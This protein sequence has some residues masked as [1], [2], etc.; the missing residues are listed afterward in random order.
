MN[1]STNSNNP[2][3]QASLTP[4]NV[5]NSQPNPQNPILDVNTIFGV[6]SVNQIPPNE[7]SQPVTSTTPSSLNEPNPSIQNPN[8]NLNPA[9]PITPNPSNP[10]P[11]APP[12]QPINPAPTPNPVSQTPNVSPTPSPTPVETLTPNEPISAPPSEPANNDEELL[13]AF[14]GQNYEKITTS[15]FN[16]AG[17]F[18]TTF[19]MFYRKMFLYSILVFLLNFL[20]STIL[21]TAAASLIISLLLGIFVNKLYLY[22]AKNKIAKI[23]LKNPQKSFSEL[24][25]I[26]QKKGG[27]SVGLAFLGTIVEFVIALIIAI[28][29][30]IIGIGTIFSQLLPDLINPSITDSEPE[31]SAPSNQKATLLEDVTVSGYSCFGDNCAISIEKDSA[32]LNYTLKAQNKDLIKLVNDY[33]KYLK[34]DIYYTTTNNTYTLTDYKVYIKSTNEDISTITTEDELRKKLGLYATG[35]YTNTFTLTEIEDPSFGYKDD[36]YYTYINYKFVDDK[37]NEYE[38][39]YINPSSTLN[40]IEG[41]KYTVTFEVK[42]GMFDYEFYIKAIY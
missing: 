3:P 2:N 32:S 9:A 35:T 31:D 28:I 13:K 12:I 15:Q 21:K 27:T 33:T 10:T 19:Y 36:D 20:I 22:Y 5:T 37:N 23:K 30:L 4:D 6:T 11:D 29:M 39:E 18:F 41:N 40:L 17:L 26:C 16:F 1:E 24:Q 14:I 7:P 25:S 38:M 34:I 42:E 8:A